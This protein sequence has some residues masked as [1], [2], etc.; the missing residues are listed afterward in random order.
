[1]L[2]SPIHAL[3]P[4]LAP[5]LRAAELSG[6]DDIEGLD[7]FLGPLD[8]ST[9]HWRWEAALEAT[10]CVLDDGEVYERQ[11]PDIEVQIALEDALPG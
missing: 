7:L 1:M 9:H 8:A 2:L 10:D 6:Q 11:L 4:N 3:I 5:T